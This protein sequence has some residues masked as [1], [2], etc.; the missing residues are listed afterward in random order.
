MKEK[1]NSLL[2]KY[3]DK[4]EDSPFIFDVQYAI[5]VL[6]INQKRKRDPEYYDELIRV[7]MREFMSKKAKMQLA[8]REGRDLDHYF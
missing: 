7:F 6:D 8:Y 4:V 1:A 2:Q 3:V 5:Y